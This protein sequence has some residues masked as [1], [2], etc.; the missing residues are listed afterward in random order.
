MGW[1]PSIPEAGSRPQGLDSW[2][3]WVGVRF[4]PALTPTHRAQ[5]TEPTLGA[6]LML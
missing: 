3:L 1:Q 4:L 5:P 6:K 2:G